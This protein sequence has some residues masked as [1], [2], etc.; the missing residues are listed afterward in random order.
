MRKGDGGTT[1]GPERDYG[2]DYR[3]PQ[4]SPR[5]NFQFDPDNRRIN[6][7][8]VD[9]VVGAWAGC[10]KNDVAKQGTNLVHRIE[11]YLR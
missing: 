1:R 10:R 4:H 6:E 8:P 5:V 3:F 2:L 7:V 11:S 9:A